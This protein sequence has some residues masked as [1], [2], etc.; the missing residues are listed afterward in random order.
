MSRVIKFL[1][2]V[3][4]N[5]VYRVELFILFFFLVVKGGGDVIRDLDEGG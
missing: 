5:A 1:Y 4:G 2:V 3:Y